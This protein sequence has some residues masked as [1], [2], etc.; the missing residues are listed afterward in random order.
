MPI[1]A[2]RAISAQGIEKG[3]M[4]VFSQ[5]DS[6]FIAK[7]GVRTFASDQEN[8]KRELSTKA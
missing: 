2:S 1:G 6:A 8:Q 5:L 3:M 4:E 7:V